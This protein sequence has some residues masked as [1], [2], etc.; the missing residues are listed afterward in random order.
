MNAVKLH[1]TVH[2]K[3]VLRAYV[4][5]LLLC[6][7]ACCFL[8]GGLPSV[9]SPLLLSQTMEAQREG[10]EGGESRSDESR[11]P[12]CYGSAATCFLPLTL[13]SLQ[14]KCAQQVFGGCVSGMDG[15]C[16]VCSLPPPLCPPSAP[17]SIPHPGQQQ[18]GLEVGRDACVALYVS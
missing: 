1:V 6:C 9:S 18:H 11:Q 5:W 10:S 8:P 2:E 4:C 12:N 15:G 17:L 13:H 3:L 14:P 16:T 7:R